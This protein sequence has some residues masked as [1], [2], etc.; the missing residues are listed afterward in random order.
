[1]TIAQKIGRKLQSVDRPLM[2]LLGMKLV[3]IEAG[4]AVIE[5]PVR[6][7]MLNGGGACQG[8]LVFAL[9]DQAF[10]YACMSGNKLGVTLSA[11]VVFNNPARLG[12]VL[13]AEA[14]VLIESGRTAT[15]DVVVRNQEDKTIA[16]FRGVH[17]RVKRA[18]LDEG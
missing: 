6:E 7:D 14:T 5:M 2:T 18:V 13:S 3:S 10:A 9:A 12:D 1:M 8:G 16:H 15:C 11:D 17:Y 4:K